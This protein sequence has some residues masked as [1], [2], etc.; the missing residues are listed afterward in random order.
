VRS[1]TKT[2]REEPVERSSWVGRTI[3]GAA[4]LLAS[5]S[6]ASFAQAAASDAPVT[7]HRAETDAR[8]IHVTVGHSFFLDTKS[9]LR[10]VYIADPAVLDSITLSPNQIIV[11]AMTPGITSL[12]LLDEEGQA[13][14]FVVSS[15]L[16]VENLRTAMSQAMPH[17][18]VGVQGMVGRVVL[19]GKVTSEAASDAAFKLAS[20]YSKDVANALIVAPGHPKQVRLQV[21]ILE[22]DRTKLMQLGINL[23]NPGGN[24]SFLASTTT[25]QYP[26]AATLTP[27]LTSGIGNLVTT[28]PLNFMLYSA[29][30][31]LGTTIQDLQSKQVLQI[32]AEP[33]ITT[34]SGEKASFLS[35]GQFPFPVVQPGGGAGS[36]SVVTIQFREF[37]VKV[38]FTPIVND[39]GTIRLH[40]T[41]EV[42]S[43]DYT[44]SVTIGGSTIPALTTRRADTDVEL[45][46]NESYAISGL[47]DQRTTDLMSKTPGAASIPILGALFKSKNT[48]HS[49]TELVVVVTPTVVDPLSEDVEPKQPE[50]PIPT[51]DTGSFDQS[52]GK[53]LNPTPAAP[54]LQQGNPFSSNVAP[55][56]PVATPVATPVTAAQKPLQQSAPVATTPVP[57]AAPVVTPAVVARVPL[58][59]S[60]P[61]PSTPKSVAVVVAPPAAPAPVLPQ[62]VKLASATPAA[63]IAPVAIVPAQVPMQLSPEALA[64]APIASITV[65]T[66]MAPALDSASHD[67]EAPAAVPEV[68][69]AVVATAITASHPMVQIMALSN[70]SD[71]D[72]MVA[73]LRRHGYNVAVTHEPQDSLLHLEVG[74]FADNSA[75]QAMRQR[76]LLEGYNAT[77]K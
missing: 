18:N 25:G 42:S 13:Q 44:N 71:A 32:L 63:Y 50:L 57:A 26:S 3:A 22:V 43:L 51:L 8:T 75:A 1:Q 36:T 64:A 70:N 38:E 56:S 12:I 69:S 59:Q 73:A 14:S 65:P 15:D 7:I 30:L 10:R 54:P 74:P 46:S 52:L 48:N 21:R 2:K 68:K 67:S 41:P 55:T 45:H 20:L 62:P 5:L 6:T 17:D 61:A 39:D 76:L 9:R 4:I 31:N 49:T 58:P 35:G 60:E 28:N 16:D 47:L 33:T 40:V 72:A 34:I 23:F 24:T 19:S 53:N 27:S 11:T 37:G 66:V 29:K 77:V